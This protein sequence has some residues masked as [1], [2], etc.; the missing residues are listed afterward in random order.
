MQRAAQDE[1]TDRKRDG[2]RHLEDENPSL[3]SSPTGY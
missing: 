2:V 1:E 3:F